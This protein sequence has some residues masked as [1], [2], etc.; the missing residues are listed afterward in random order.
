MFR[1]MKELR[2]LER[3]SPAQVLRRQRELLADMIR[4]TVE[5]VPHYRP[6]AAL[7]EGLD[8]SNAAE[9]LCQ[10]PIL[11]KEALQ[12]S[13]GRLRAE[14]WKGRF[15]QKTTGGSTGRPVT[16]LKN[17]SAIAQEMAATWMAYGWFDVRI[18][19]RSVRFWGQPQ[20]NFRR[21]L[22]YF[23]ADVAVNRK[24][25]SAFGYDREDLSRYVDRIRRFRPTY[26]YGYV[27][28]LEDLARHLL[29][30]GER[31]D[32]RLPRHVVT[33]AEVLTEPQRGSWERRLVLR[34]RTS[35]GVEKPARSHMTAL[36][37][38][39]TCCRRTSTWRSSTT[40]DGLSRR[41]SRA[42]SC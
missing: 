21:R 29:D 30:C 39:S 20:K 31:F 7:A 32:D 3:Q 35:T 24:T 8:A 41:A 11:E 5:N 42:R 38:P 27:S 19:D 37:A 15:S 1:R 9:R 22:R 40:T 14:G 6:S 34:S 4:F 2:R 36:E 13:P 12:E 25:L 28:A 33:T 26:L 23:A 10:F 16:L 18:G 17:S